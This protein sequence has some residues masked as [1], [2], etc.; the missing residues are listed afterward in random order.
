MGPSKKSWQFGPAKKAKGF[1]VNIMKEVRE[2]EKEEE[3]NRKARETAALKVDE[4]KVPELN[5]IAVT[6]TDNAPVAKA[7]VVKAPV[8]K[9]PVVKKTQKATKATKATESIQ[10]GSCDCCG[11]ELNSKT[12]ELK[13]GCKFCAENNEYLCKN[14]ASSSCTRIRGVYACEVHEKHC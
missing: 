12:V 14:C 2:M 8:V 3:M 4:N 9:A 1:K 7:P 6:K 5:V 10:Y 11:S 13:K